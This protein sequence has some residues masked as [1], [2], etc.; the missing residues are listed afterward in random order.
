MIQSKTYETYKPSTIK[1]I[2][3]IPCHWEIVPFYSVVKESKRSN[4]GLVE[5][6]VLSLSYG[7]IIKKPKSRHMGLVPASYETYQIVEPGEMI[8]RFTDLQNDKRSLRSAEVTD[9]GIIT[10]AYLAV[11]PIQIHSR[12][13]AWLMRSYDL[14]KVFYS[15]GGGL[16]QSLNFEDVRRLPICLPSQ[17]EQ[18]KISNLIDKRVKQIDS[19]IS[20]KNRFLELLKEKVLATVMNEQM[21]GSGEL[22]RL[23]YL[24][25]RISRP[26]IIEENEEYIALGLYNRG[27]GLF[28][29]APSLGKDMGD[30]NFFCVEEGDLILSGQFAWE[31]AVTIAS[32]KQTGCIVSHR[33]PVVR[34][35]SITTEYLSALL[36]TNFGDFL[37]NESSR[38]AAGRNR[39]LNIERLLN[40][41]I[42]M[43][44]QKVQNEVTKLMN[45][46]ALAERKIKKSIEL[47][48]ERRTAYITAAVTGKIDLRGESA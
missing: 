12:Y 39:P 30:S 31:G 43:P 2:K 1:W 33:Y 34:G 8:F 6:T 5:N 35:T 4:I 38:G 10:S 45:F 7:K 47:L 15:M 23:K 44:S 27:R 11:Q 21:Q 25:E 20:K 37:L 22:V 19:L 9:K 26:V 40:E 14:C 46:K 18:E 24:T 36:M 13:L 48:R 16:R 32:D 42:R 3:E 28:H 41:K 29:K 17:N